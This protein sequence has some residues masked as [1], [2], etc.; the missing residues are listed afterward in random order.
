MR[1]GGP[2]GVVDDLGGG[3]G[4]NQSRRRSTIHGVPRSRPS[5]APWRR[6][7]DASCS[8]ISA[9]SVLQSMV[10]SWLGERMPQ[11]SPL[12]PA[13]Q[14]P[15]ARPQSSY[16]TEAL[17]SA[18]SLMIAPRHLGLKQVSAAAAPTVAAL[19]IPFN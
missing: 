2:G 1:L 11:P 17:G 15:I 12:R 13:R 9:A 10:R 7:L 16:V 8:L 6:G 19:V 3:R 4:S 18:S 5:A 14:D